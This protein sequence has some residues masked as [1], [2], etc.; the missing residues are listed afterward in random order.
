MELDEAIISV[1]NG[2]FSSFSLIRTAP[3]AN[4]FNSAKSINNLTLCR[5]AIVK[6]LEDWREG[7]LTDENVHEWA[8]FMRRGYIPNQ[9]ITA[10][11]PIDIIYCHSHEE[12]IAEIISKLDQIGDKIDGT[13]SD[14]DR[15]HF[16]KKLR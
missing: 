12:I 11:K 13:I 7:V 3:H 15:R 1:L 4:L 5:S 10:I 9:N 6:I 8:S 16:L 2:D 14:N